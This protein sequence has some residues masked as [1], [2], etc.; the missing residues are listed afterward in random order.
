MSAI[1]LTTYTELVD[2]RKGRGVLSVTKSET[3]VKNSNVSF[4][5]KKRG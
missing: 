2:G 4:Y 5:Q 1:Q 3:G